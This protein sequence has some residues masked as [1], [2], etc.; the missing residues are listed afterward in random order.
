MLN[1]NQSKL[2]NFIKRNINA[3]KSPK[4]YNQILKNKLRCLVE[5]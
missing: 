5:L 2:F 1:I 4:L 3:K